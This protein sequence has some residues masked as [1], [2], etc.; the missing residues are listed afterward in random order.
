MQSV[1]GVNG[2]VDACDYFEL[3]I[4]RVRFIEHEAQKE[5]PHIAP[6]GENAVSLRGVRKI[7]GARRHT[8]GLVVNRIDRRPVVNVRNFITNL[9]MFRISCFRGTKPLAH[10]Y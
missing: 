2:F 9:F 8:E 1:R 7:K 10:L 4:E 6:F 3:L 5:I